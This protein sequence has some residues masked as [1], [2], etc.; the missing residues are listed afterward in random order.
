MK[1]I[2]FAGISVFSFSESYIGFFNFLILLFL[3]PLNSESYMSFILSC[4]FGCSN[5]MRNCQARLE[6]SLEAHHGPRL[7]RKIL[8]SALKQSSKLQS[9]RGN[10]FVL[11][12]LFFSL[13]KM[14]LFQKAS[15]RKKLKF[16]KAVL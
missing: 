3:V 1:K 4:C 6:R 10:I 14:G 5:T 8:V 7:M 12:N 9:R 15:P 2:H 16:K 11:H 13:L